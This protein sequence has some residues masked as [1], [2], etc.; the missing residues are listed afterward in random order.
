M[1]IVR[2]AVSDPE[3]DRTATAR[4]A[5]LVETTG[6]PV[7]RVWTP[8]RQVAFGRR[9]A[10]ADGYERAREMALEYG[11]EP[12]ERSVGGRAVAYT[13][14]TVAFVYGVTTDGERNDVQARYRGVTDLLKRALRSLGV[15][16]WSGEPDGAFCPGDHS[17]QRDGKLVGLAQRIRRESALVGGCVVVTKRDEREIPAVL[18][19]VYGA[20]DIPFDPA[21]TASI[22][23]VIGTAGPQRVIDA[24]ESTFVGGRDVEVVEV[25]A[26]LADTP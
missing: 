16:V 8:P 18:E 9:D 24:I 26:L 25:P 7:L 4:L 12:V 15:V 5:D 2:G 23:G 17:L 1:R 11:Y 22:E 3:R 21:S 20:L 6:E 10:V 14:E 19:P 13:G